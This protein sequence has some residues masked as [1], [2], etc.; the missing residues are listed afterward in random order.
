MA[1]SSPKKTYFLSDFHLGVPG[2]VESLE[3]EKRIVQFLREAAKDAAHI[4]IVGD[5]F[6]FLFFF[7]TV[8]PK[9]YTRML[10]MLA[11]LTDNGIP[12]SFFVGNHDMW[13]ND[14]VV[15]YVHTIRHDR[16]IGDANV[17]SQSSRTDGRA[18]ANRHSTSSELVP[19]RAILA[20]QRDALLS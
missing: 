18:R 5:M 14:H 16:E 8:V 17:V 10:G 12:V 1:L 6:D 20:Q 19:V 11:E 3:R 4:F 2:R 9:G 13:M 15:S 7:K